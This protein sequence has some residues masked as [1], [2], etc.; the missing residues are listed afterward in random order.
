VSQDDDVRSPVTRVWTETDQETGEV[1]EIEVP[2]W[3]DDLIEANAKKLK[4]E[5]GK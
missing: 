4:E 2:V 1:R 5:E 3:L